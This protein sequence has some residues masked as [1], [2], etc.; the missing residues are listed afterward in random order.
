MG[1]EV[2]NVTTRWIVIQNQA[3]QQFPIEI[4]DVESFLIRWPSSLAAL[5]D[6][7]LVEAVGF[8]VGSNTLQ[9]AHIDHFEG[10]DRSMVAPTTQNVLPEVRPLNFF[11]PGYDVFMNM[12]GFAGAQLPY[13]YWGRLMGPSVGG[14]ATRRI[15]GTAVERTP[16]RLAI[17]G[18]NLAM[19]VPDNSGQMTITRVT[20]GNLSYARKGD[21][22]FLT[23]Q[24]PIQ[25]T[26]RGVRAAQLVLYKQTPFD[27]FNP[28]K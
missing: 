16:L 7:S 13:E 23:P 26:P 22:A 5:T 15:V 6:Q 27:Q 19:I 18:N 28:N 25:A 2:I 4:E 10:A 8:D 24:F 9:T 20:K 21:Y 17:P 14:I 12:F 1:G 3:G 11:D